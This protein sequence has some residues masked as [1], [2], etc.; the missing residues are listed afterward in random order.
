MDVIIFHPFLKIILL[1]NVKN[2]NFLEN[3]TF[4]G[5]GCVT[6]WLVFKVLSVVF[7]PLGGRVFFLTHPLLYH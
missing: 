2:N 5:E 6:N 3:E 1:N 4:W 7:Q